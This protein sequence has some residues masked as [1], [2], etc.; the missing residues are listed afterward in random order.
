MILRGRDFSRK[1]LKQIKNIVEQNS[2]ISRRKLSFLV[3]EQL[4]WRQPNGSLKDRA[5]RDVLLRL[6]AR[7]IVKLPSPLY[8]RPTQLLTVYSPENDVSEVRLQGK[9]NDFGELRFSLVST[10]DQRKLWNYLIDQHHYLG[11][12]TQVGRHL[13]FFLYL[14]NHL[15]GAMAFADAVLK[16]NLRDHWIGWTIQHREQNLHLIINN[17]RFLILPTVKIKNLA[18]K[19]LALAT[20]I[21]PDYWQHHYGF[22]PQLMET[23]IE[24]NRFKRSSYRAANW[25][26]LG[27]TIGKARRGMNYSWHGVKKHYCVYPL[28]KG[29]REMLRGG[30]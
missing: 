7:E 24:I 18:S 2:D 8:T 11:I 5:C 22:R 21:I 4:D 25:I 16:L 15:I 14:E 23:F 6:A 3:C 13:K 29:A 28:V 17:T 30:S 27:E 10:L 12:S 26:F 1:E 9:I 20:K 19:T